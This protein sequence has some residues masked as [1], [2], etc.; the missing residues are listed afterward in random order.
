MIDDYLKKQL[1]GKMFKIFCDLIMG[2]V[3]INDILQLIEF[4]AKERVDKSK[5]MTVNSITHNIKIS[6]VD[7]CKDPK[8]KWVK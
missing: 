2:Y 1:Q 3:H 7:V 5:N 6:H 8:I 4:E